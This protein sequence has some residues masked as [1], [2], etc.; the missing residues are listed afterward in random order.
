MFGVT[1]AVVLH[2][3]L[4]RETQAISLSEIPLVI[5]LLYAAPLTLLWTRL[6]GSAVVLVAYRRQPRLKLL[7]NLTMQA[8][9]VSLAE[10]LFH[11]VGHP[12][13][14]L[15][16][17]AVAGVD[18][19]GAA[20]APPAGGPLCRGPGRAGGPLPP[21]RSPLEVVDSAPAAASVPP[22]GFAAPS[23]LQPGPGAAGALLAIRGGLL[24]AY[25]RYGLLRR[26]HE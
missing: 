25:R 9:E 7:Y 21:S 24:S 3:Q 5:G 26:R 10:W 15:D 23:A 13:G 16:P 12:H 6:A 18:V 8:A 1:E 2:V 11:R 20:P 14:S 22:R 17:R 19:G 4:R